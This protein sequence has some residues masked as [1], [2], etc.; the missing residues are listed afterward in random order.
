M[1]IQTVKQTFQL[2]REHQ[3][4][5]Y[6]PSKTV[7]DRDLGSSHFVTCRPNILGLIGGKVKSYAQ[8]E[9][10]RIIFMRMLIMRKYV[11]QNA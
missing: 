9:H 4:R 6:L 3:T 5:D 10:A 11:E 1:F 2:I 8:V 7:W